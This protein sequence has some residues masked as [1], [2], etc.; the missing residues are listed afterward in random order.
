MC[1]EKDVHIFGGVAR[2]HVKTTQVGELTGG[3]AGLFA[4]FAGGAEGGVFV[5]VQHAGGQLE[6]VGA[7]PQAVLANEED[8]ALRILRE[9]GDGVIVFDQ[10]VGV[11]AP[12]WQAQLVLGHGEGFAGVNDCAFDQLVRHALRTL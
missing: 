10:V 3:K 9:D 6:Q 2:R 11:G 1:G 12:I 7:G 4:H 5:V 8:A